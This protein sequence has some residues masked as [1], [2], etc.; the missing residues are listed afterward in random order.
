MA[1]VVETVWLSECS[2]LFLCFINSFNLA[3][4]LFLSDMDLAIKLRVVYC[5]EYS[6]VLVRLYLLINKFFR[7][8]FD[9]SGEIIVSGLKLGYL[10]GFVINF[11]IQFRYF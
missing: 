1:I 4:S 9:F 3:S 10:L 5:I 6:R 2:S 11:I 7:K 8:F